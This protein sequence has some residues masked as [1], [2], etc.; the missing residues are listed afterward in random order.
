MPY[1]EGTDYPIT[2]FLFCCFMA[3]NALSTF[4]CLDDF[5]SLNNSRFD[6]FV[7]RIYTTELEIKDTTDTDGFASYLDLHIE[8]ESERRLRT[9]LYDKRDD[10]NFTI[11]NFPFICNNI[12]ATPA[13]ELCISQLIRY[14]R[15]CGSYQDFLDRN[16]KLW[17][18]VSS[19]RYILHV[20]VLL[21]CCYI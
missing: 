16:H 19:E 11:V 21:E 9:K 10:F 4:R 20:Q 2:C 17:N 15:A 7:D 6:D 8:I 1:H 5:I 14:S 12:P 13:Y 18:I 3:F